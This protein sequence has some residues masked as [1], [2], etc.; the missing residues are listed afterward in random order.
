MEWNE[1]KSG[2][3]SCSLAVAQNRKSPGVWKVYFSADDANIFYAY[4]SGFNLP[5]IQWINEIK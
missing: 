4:F 2:A 3:S 1:T 5:Q